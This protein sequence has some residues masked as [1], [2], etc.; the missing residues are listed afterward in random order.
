MFPIT[1]FSE[2]R[3]V[4]GALID[5]D[6]QTNRLE[7][8]NTL[9]S[10]FVRTRLI[11]RPDRK[12]WVENK[13][14]VGKA[15]RMVGQTI[16]H[17][18]ALLCLL[19]YFWQKHVIR[20]STQHSCKSL[21]RNNNTFMSWMAYSR[22]FQCCYINK[23]RPHINHSGSSR[24]KSVVSTSFLQYE[25]LF[26]NSGN[27]NSA[28]EPVDVFPSAARCGYSMLCESVCQELSSWKEVLLCSVR[29]CEVKLWW[30]GEFFTTDMMEFKEQRICIKFCFNL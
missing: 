30:S 2:F 29:F 16:Q 8:T 11:T 4:R 23:V 28:P 22:L 13:M 10:L 3:P 6:R 24:S 20:M 12:F 7:E 5:V 17:V 15:E 25:V 14:C 21:F 1:I 19:K 9:F 26:K 18:R 27:L